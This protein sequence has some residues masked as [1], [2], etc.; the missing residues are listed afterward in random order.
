MSVAPSQFPTSHPHQP[1]PPAQPEPLENGDRLTRAEFER[2]YHA[3]PEVKKAELIEG[4]VY[5][6]SPVRNRRHGRPH[7]VLTTWLGYYISKTPGLEDFADNATVRIDEDNEPQPDLMLLMPQRL[8]GLAHTDDDDY[9]NGP[10]TL[11]CEV[12][13][14]SVSLDLH[15]KLNVYRRNGV[16]EY[17]VWRT[18]DNAVD[19]FALR[20]GQYL[21]LPPEPAGLL[22]SNEFPG[23][24]L[25][26]PALLR[27]DLPALF[28]A[29][30]EGARSPEHAAFV[31]RLRAS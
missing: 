15:A 9:V 14:S 19:W 27:N 4:I 8:G 29:I 20:D 30:D 3:M 2:R 17:L 25:D 18:L 24:W 13:A 6:P 23:L 22:K 12:A 28:R 5:M 10:P 11:V 1:S 16:R 21:P 26:A 31:E 7:V